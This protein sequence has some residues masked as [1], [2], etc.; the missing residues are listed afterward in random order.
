[1]SSHSTN[2]Q[3]KVSGPHLRRRYV[4]NHRTP[5]TQVPMLSRQVNQGQLKHVRK[6]CLEHNTKGIRADGSR[7]E[8]S[9]K[10]WN[11]LRRAQP[12]GVTM[13]NALGHD[14]VLRRNVRVAFSRSDMTPFIKFTRGSHH[15]QLCNTSR[16]ST[17][18]C[19]KRILATNYWSFLNY[20]SSIQARLLGWSHLTMLQRSV[21]F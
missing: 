1:M 16:S 3:T 21:V 18:H 14:F 9:H 6:G 8:G 19:S 4:W 5:K 13:L 7:I 15:L 11:F 17:I 20:A 2:G 10:G 12:S